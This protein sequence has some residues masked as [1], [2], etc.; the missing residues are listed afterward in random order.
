MYSMDKLRLFPVLTGCILFLG[1][2]ITTILIST[3][4]AQTVDKDGKIIE[5]GDLAAVKKAASN[6]DLVIANGRVIDPETKLDAI[7]F[8]GVN[9]G[10]IAAVSAEPL[11]GNKV[12]DASGLGS[13]NDVNAC[14]STYPETI[15]L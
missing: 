11:V 10:S 15:L 8:V 3:A 7:R 5:V 1:L 13:Q 12:I 9:G 2:N 14:F 4:F 6:Y